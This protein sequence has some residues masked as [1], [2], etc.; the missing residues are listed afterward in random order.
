MQE[1]ELFRRD[2]RKNHMD[3]ADPGHVESDSIVQRR[4]RHTSCKQHRMQCGL[5]G[6]DIEFC[7]L[8]KQRR[9][10][11][12]VAILTRCN[13][14]LGSSLR[15]RSGRH[16]D[17]NHP[18]IRTLRSLS[19]KG[20]TIQA[21]SSSNEYLLPRRRRYL[22]ASSKARSSTGPLRAARKTGHPTGAK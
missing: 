7:V 2:L 17:E 12:V 15:F 3:D 22:R 6:A 19:V 13:D 5:Y 9:R 4:P 18:E 21:Y 1:H 8:S 11:Y 14:G 16:G 20:R 10:R